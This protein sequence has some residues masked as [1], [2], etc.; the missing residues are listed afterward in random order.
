MRSC[1]KF[2]ALA[3]LLSFSSAYADLVPTVSVGSPEANCNGGVFNFYK[4]VGE[5]G[6]FRD[7][8]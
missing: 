7:I 2:F 6:W 3:A 4:Y 1:I 5:T 8:L